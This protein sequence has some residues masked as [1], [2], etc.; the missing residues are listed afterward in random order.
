MDSPVEIGRLLLEKSTLPAA[1]RAIIAWGELYGKSFAISEW[2]KVIGHCKRGTTTSPW[3]PPPFPRARISP[4]LQR[5]RLSLDSIHV[6]SL[7]RAT[8]HVV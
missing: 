1:E 4:Y 3:P 2:L 5:A 7:I 8:S 6:R